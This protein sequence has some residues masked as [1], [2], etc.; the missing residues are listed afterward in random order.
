MKKRLLLLAMISILTVSFF[1]P[2]KVVY[3]DYEEVT[4]VSFTHEGIQETIDFIDPVKFVAIL[5]GQ[6]YPKSADIVINNKRA[7]AGYVTIYTPDWHL[8]STGLDLKYELV[9]QVQAGKYVITEINEFGDS[10]IPLDGFVIQFGS[11]PTATYEVGDEI[12]LA[13]YTF[14]PADKA[15]E[16]STGKRVLVDA[17]D[18]VRSRPMIVYYDSK[19]GKMTGNNQWGVEITVNLDLETSIFS[20]SDFREIG[21]GDSK[22][23]EIPYFGFV[24]SAYGDPYR[25]KLAKGVLFNVDDELQVYGIPFVDLSATV[26]TNYDYLNPT[27]EMNPSGMDGDQPFP[28]L[29]GVDQLIIYTDAWDNQLYNGN[30]TGTGTNEWGYEIAVNSEG[31]VVETGINV[32]VIPEGGFVAS[33]HGLGRDWLRS[34]AIIGSMCEYDALSQT[35]TLT[36]TSDSYISVIKNSKE[37][38]IGELENA[39]RKLFDINAE[40]AYETLDLL[41]LEIAKLEQLSL[42]LKV[43]PDDFGKLVQFKQALD[44]ANDYVNKVIYM[45]YPSRVIDSR[46]VWH[47]PNNAGYNELTL[48]GV[49]AFLDDL[50][51]NH[52]NSVYVETFFH[53]Y[54]ITPNMETAELHPWLQNGSYGEYGNDYLLAFV[55]EAKKRNIEVHAWVQ[56]FNVGFENMVYPSFLTN[57]PSWIMLNDDQTI[58]QRNEGGKYIF[59]DPANPE[60]TDYLLDVYLELMTN[61][62]LDG[63]HLDYIRYPVSNRLQDTGYT[64]YA[65]QEFKTENNIANEVDFVQLVKTDDDIYQKWIDYKTEKVT[66]FVKSVVDMMDELD[67]TSIISTAIFPDTVEAISKKNQDWPTWVKNGWIDITTPM[68]YYSDANTVKNKIQDMVLFVDGVTLNYAGIAPAFMGL[69]VYN[70]PLQAFQARNGNAFGAVFFASQNLTGYGPVSESFL[71]GLYQKEAILPHDDIKLIIE[72]MT[73]DLVGENSKA[74]RIYIPAEKMTEAQKL[75]LK[76]ELDTISQMNYQ[77][78]SEVKLIVTALSD[79]IS[80]V[81]DF[82]SGFADNRIEE[83]LVYLN[84]ILKVRVTRLEINEGVWQKP[85]T[86]P[87]PD[88]D[89]DPDPVTCELNEELIDGEC[90]PIEEPT[91]PNTVLIAAISS[92]VVILSGVVFFVIKKNKI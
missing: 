26:E 10:Y 82:G 65:I 55:T 21:E 15:I 85:G 29:R 12:T 32:S 51:H 89:P 71:L 30:G 38:A 72:T 63:L 9:V 14:H 11:L 7:R 64:S 59:A 45:T 40:L 41:T 77:T 46:G 18:S 2:R 19:Y 83:D 22:G 66:D 13:G 54:V 17:I 62:E 67:N 20:I 92:A 24:L 91:T 37:R 84:E 44:N 79:L 70:N 81:Q 25:L 28:S 31:I 49:E 34:N 39:V 73:N 86:N 4:G 6:G 47:R 50:Q 80:R 56:N 76:A 48:E 53:G 43:T 1:Q 90:V 88:P 35:L 27:P 74:D 16:S 61:Y 33:G 69:E 58:L 52:I 75:A 60:V 42:D 57:N 68:A 8:T 5:D 78:S 23:I 3:G 87:N 36:T